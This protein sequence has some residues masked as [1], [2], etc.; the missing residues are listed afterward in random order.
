MGGTSSLKKLAEVLKI[1][2]ALSHGQASVE[3]GFSVNKSFLVENLATK[4][5][6]P[7]MIVYEHMKVNNVSAKN[8]EI[9]PT[10]SRSVKHAR[11]RYSIYMEQQKKN[12]V[13]NDRSLKRKRVQEEIIAVNKRK[14]ML[15]N[16]IQELTD[17]ADKY[18]MDT[19]NVSKIEDMKT[20]SSRCNS[21]GTLR[22]RNMKK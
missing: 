13:Q 12:E 4:S 10:L 14:A 22:R 8:V 9:Y 6:I 11:H 15:E 5:L 7:Q 16:T 1:I 19:E 17:D 18:A 3:S 20:L 21:F 2:L